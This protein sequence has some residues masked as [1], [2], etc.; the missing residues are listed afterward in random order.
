MN[1]QKFDKNK[2]FKSDQGRNQ[3]LYGKLSDI[4]VLIVSRSRNTTVSIVLKSS[5][6]KAR[7]FLQQEISFVKNS[8]CHVVLIQVNQ[9]QRLIKLLDPFELLINKLAILYIQKT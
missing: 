7:R 4:I 3:I 2:L 5:R 1:I 8:N 6:K 9:Y